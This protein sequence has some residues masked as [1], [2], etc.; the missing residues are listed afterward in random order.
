[1][2]WGALISAGASL[3]GGAMANSKSNASSKYEMAWQERMSNTAHQREVA[4]LRA[5]GLNPI[6]SAGGGGASAS[7][8]SSYKA[9]DI[10]S[11]AVNSAQA[12]RRLKEELRGMDLQNEGQILQNGTKVAEQNLLEQQT[13]KTK[14]ED[15]LTKVLTVKALE[16]AKLSSNNARTSALNARMMEA[17]L[18]AALSKESIENTQFGRAL[19]Y[20]DRIFESIGKAFGNSA[21]ANSR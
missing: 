8:G 21:K 14:S 10:L 16:D 9:E 2:A 5:A 6:L 12:A 3:L 15:A 11:P 19:Q 17:A 20:S 7:G 4:D 13:K 18:P 1:M